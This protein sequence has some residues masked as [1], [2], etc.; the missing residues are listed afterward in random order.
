MANGTFEDPVLYVDVLF[1]KRALLFDA[2]N[3]R[4]LSSKKLMRVSDVFVSHAHMDHFSDFDWLLR[5]R[6]GRMRPL[7]LYGPT[8]FIARV[9]SKLSAYSWNLVHNYEDDFIITVTELNEDGHGKKAT[10]RCRE[11]FR[12]SHEESC[13]VR[14]GVLI[15]EAAFRV[16]SAIF[17]HS[18]PVLGYCIEERQHVNVWK[19]RLDELG[20]PVGPWLRNLKQAVLESRPDDTPIAITDQ[21]RDAG[22]REAMSLGLL[23]DR[24]L[25][26]VPGQK[27]GYLVDVVF[28]E[29]NCL[30]AAEL[31]NDCDLLFIECAFLHEDAKVAGQKN[32]LTARQAGEIA[33]LARAKR[34]IPI[35]FSPRYSDREALLRSE[36]ESSFH[37]SC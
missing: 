29:I 32:H 13:Q 28:N 5:L 9:E 10:F 6:V 7:R 2:G 27:I 21:A 26:I 8:G 37:G 16:R 12:I 19:N 14:A 17:D 30:R 23:R 18:I 33:G 34:V 36:A 4:R 22:K 25:R 24:V 15:E 1:E 35:H 11:G 3:L 31:F 20:L